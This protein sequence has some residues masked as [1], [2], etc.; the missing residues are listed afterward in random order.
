MAT[1]EI[2]IDSTD[3]SFIQE[4]TL[5]GITYR[6]TFRWNSRESAWYMHVEESDGT[7]IEYSIKLVTGT[8]FMW[9]N[10]KSTKPPGRLFLVSA[11]ASD[12]PGRYEL[13]AEAKLVYAEST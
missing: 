2:P 10:P 7:G 4:V 11:G 12:P 3:P 6:F 8:L 13:G 1:L 5:E 9:R